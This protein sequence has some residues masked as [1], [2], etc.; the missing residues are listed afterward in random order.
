M[1]M[2]AMRSLT[3]SGAGRWVAL[4]VLCR[5]VFMSAL[6][7]TIVNVVLPSVRDDL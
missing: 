3:S 1:G 2:E 7:S 4:I 5:G 6:D